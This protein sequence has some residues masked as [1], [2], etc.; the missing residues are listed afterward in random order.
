MYIL[1]QLLLIVKMS[2]L[3]K[4][5]QTKI[6]LIHIDEQISKKILVIIYVIII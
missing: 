1:Y 5:Q 4:L 6:N 2:T 3:M